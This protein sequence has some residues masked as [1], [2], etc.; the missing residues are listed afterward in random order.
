M[1]SPLLCRM[2]QQNYCLSLV[3]VF[4]LLVGS[5]KDYFKPFSNTALKIVCDIIDLM[6]LQ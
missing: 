1:V 4:I 6:V 5:F 3:S 2:W